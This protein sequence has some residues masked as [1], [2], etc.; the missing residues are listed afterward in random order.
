MSKPQNPTSVPP[1]RCISTS[2]FE[3]RGSF[4]QNDQVNESQ[5]SLPGKPRIATP[6]SPSSNNALPECPGTSLGSPI[7]SAVT[8]PGI[9]F[10]YLPPSSLSSEIQ[11]S[12]LGISGVAGRTE[13]HFE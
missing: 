5:R 8:L 6:L 12:K 4:T 2:W 1:V 11:A 3:D 13:S 9:S 7:F 10:A